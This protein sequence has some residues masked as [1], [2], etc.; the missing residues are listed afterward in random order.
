MRFKR[1]DLPGFAIA[2]LAPPLLTLL[3][4]ATY[5]VWGHRGTPLIGFM[6]TNIAVAI[7]LLAM[8]TRFVR[9]WYVPGGVLLLLLGCVATILWMRYS[10]T[11]GSALA[12][13]LKLLSVLLFFVVN[14]AIAWQVLANGL[15]PMLDRRAERRRDGAA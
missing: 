8:F 3:F 9:N 1:S 15:L 12:T 2:V 14:A 6:A 4:L 10:G 11:D 13:G 7:G 5:D